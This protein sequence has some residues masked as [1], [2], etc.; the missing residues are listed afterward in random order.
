M[1]EGATWHPDAMTFTGDP[2]LLPILEGAGIDGVTLGN[3]H[4]LDAGAPGI[5]ETIEH[6]R[7]AGISH[8]G[9]GM[10]LSSAREPMIFD[11]GGTRVGV[12]NYQGVPSYEW[13]WATESAP[14]TA[15]LREEVMVEDVRRLRPEVDLLVVMP[16]WGREYLATPEPGQRSSSRTR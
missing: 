11:L 6:L 2:R 4:I 9:A 1:V 14:G 10:D 5:S 16:H 3:N 15:P 13:A 7:G 8:T 12:L